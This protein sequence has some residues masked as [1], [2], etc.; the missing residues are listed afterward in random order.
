VWV[1]ASC[2]RILVRIE[3]LNATAAVL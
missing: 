3:N 2:D 1:T